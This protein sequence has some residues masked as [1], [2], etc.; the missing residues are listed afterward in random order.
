MPTHNPQP[1]TAADFLRFQ[2]TS[3]G[4]MLGAA[5]LHRKTETIDL[6]ITS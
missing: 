3:P 2:I 4:I 6:I 5:Q 1:K